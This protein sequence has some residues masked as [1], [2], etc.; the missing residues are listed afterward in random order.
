MHDRLER[1]R[2]KLATTEDPDDR[3]DLEAAITALEE[4]LG[5]QTAHAG[6]TITVGNLSQVTGVAVGVGARATVYIDGRQGKT[7]DE[8]L[9]AYYQRLAL[10]CRLA[11]LRGVYEP[12]TMYDNLEIELDRVYLHLATTRLTERERL[13]GEEKRGLDFKSFLAQHTGSVLLP[14]QLRSEVAFLQGASNPLSFEIRIDTQAG[15]FLKPKDPLDL[16]NPT[17]TDSSAIDDAD[18]VIFFGPQLISEA[19]TEAP[20]LVLLG[21]PG[22]GKSTALRYLSYRLAIAG[23]DQQINLADSLIGWTA[24]R[25]L[26]VFASLLPLAKRFATNP[27]NHG[28]AQDLW[29]DLVEHLQPRGANAGLAAAVHEELE[30]GRVI[31]L[32]DGLDEIAG[33]ESRRKVV[34]AIQSFASRYTACR[35]VISCRSRAYEGER[36]AAWQLPGWPTAT[37]ADWT[38]GQMLAFVHAWYQVIAEMRGRT[39]AWRQ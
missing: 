39:N 38:I 2:H 26:P 14:S 33:D 36:N 21:G 29:D 37:L 10:R 16:R 8:L 9:A 25:L 18:T 24:G 28:A 11:P 34:R 23:L 12:Q 17:A 27:S 13:G 31:L 32:L 19:L 30:A 20:R 1:L 5:V 4:K 6:D 35:M 7:N 22:S 15:L 3:A